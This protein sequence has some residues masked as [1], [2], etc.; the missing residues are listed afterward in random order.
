MIPNTLCTL[1]APLNLTGQNY[2]RYAPLTYDDL[3]ILVPLPK[4]TFRDYRY[5]EINVEGAEVEVLK[6]SAEI[7]KLT[8]YIIF[9]ASRQT[10]ESCLGIL[11]GFDVK[12]IEES[13]PGTFN[14]IAIKRG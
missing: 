3:D 5:R 13:G 14:F 1:N 8:D 4:T 12:F 6:G 9:E 7:L 10:I 11:S 2:C